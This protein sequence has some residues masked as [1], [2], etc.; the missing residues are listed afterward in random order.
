MVL[1]TMMRTHMMTGR[2]LRV[3]QLRGAAGVIQPK[4]G[5][6]TWADWNRFEALLEIG[7][8]AAREFLGLP[9]P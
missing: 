3:Q 6:A 9:T 8:A 1:D 2:L 5:Y 4:V 7:R